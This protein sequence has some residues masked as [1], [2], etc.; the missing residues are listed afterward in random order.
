MKHESEVTAVVCD[1]GTLGIALAEKLAKTFRKVCFH[2]PI[3]DEFRNIKACCH[4]YGVEGVERCDDFLDPDVFDEADL[5]IFPDI[6]WGGTQKYLRRAG[7]A[8]WGSMGADDFELYRTRFISLLEKM[9]LPI[10]PSVKI[11]GLTNLAL[12]LEKN[13][14]KWIK[15]NCYRDNMET[16]HHISWGHSRLYLDE[17]AVEFGG[18]KDEIVFVVQD[19]LE[20]DVEIGYDGWTVDGQ[21][22]SAVFSGYEKKNELYLG[23]WLDAENLPDVVKEINS[24]ISPVLDGYGYRNMLATELRVKDDVAY[25][26][27]P[28]FRMAGQT[29]EHLTNTCDNL[30]EVIWK[31]Y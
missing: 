3:D 27:D 4:G 8:V 14:N 18:L 20:T 19:D 25:F 11:K 15:V 17:L 9:E 24:A 21:F 5:Y 16:W 23:S 1:Y 7:K 29:Q 22:P 28:T 2:S 13:E 31:V 12:Y 6:G 10:I 30:P 26:I